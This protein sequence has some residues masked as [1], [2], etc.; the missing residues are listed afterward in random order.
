M[1]LIDV[2]GELDLV[3]LAHVRAIQVKR[4]G[5]RFGV[6]FEFSAGD[7]ETYMISQEQWWVLEGELLDLMAEAA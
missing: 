7:A 4:Y 3:N 5:E 2:T 1:H 6:I